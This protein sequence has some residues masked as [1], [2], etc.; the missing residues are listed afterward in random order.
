[1]SSA[2]A[3]AIKKGIT[4]PGLAVEPPAENVSEPK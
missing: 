2:R 4:L 3:K 1:M